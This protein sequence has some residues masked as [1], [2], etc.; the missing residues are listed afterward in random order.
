MPQV[1]TTPKCVL[2]MRPCLSDFFYFCFW[3][4]FG[5]MCSFRKLVKLDTVDSN[6]QPLLQQYFLASAWRTDSRTLCI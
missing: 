5:G 1:K 2:C 4:N 3:E 6:G